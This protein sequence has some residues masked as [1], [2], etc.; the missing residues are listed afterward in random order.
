MKPSEFVAFRNRLG[1][2]QTEM[3]QLIGVTWQAVHYWET[4]QR[5]ISLTVV[6][7]LR[8]IKK[9]PQLLEEF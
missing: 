1:L 9:Y 5:K 7:V 6:K 4:G 8:L 2:S 3:A